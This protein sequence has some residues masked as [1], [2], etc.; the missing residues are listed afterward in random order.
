MTDRP[1]RDFDDLLLDSAGA[2]RAVPVGPADGSTAEST[3]HGTAA[4]TAESAPTAHVRES[5]PD[6]PRGSWFDD[7]HDHLVATTGR[8]RLWELGLPILV[9]VVAAVLR[10]WNL[11]HPRSLVFDETF[12]VKDAWTL[13]N[14]GFEGAWPENPDPGFATGAVDVFTGAPSFVVHPPLGKWIIGLGMGLLGADDSVGWRLATAIVGILAVALVIVIGKLLFRSTFLASLAGLLLAIDGHAIVMSRVS[15]LDGILMFVALCGVAA[16]LLDRRW[17]EE[18]MAVKV[19]A[20]DLPS[21]GPVLWWRPWLLTA[22]LIFGLAAGVKWTGIYFLA[23]Y[24]VYAV[25]VD[26]LLRR[27]A[28][29]PFWVSGA[30]LKQGPVTFLLVV[31]I[32]LIAYLGTWLGW[33]RTSGGWARQWATEAP[34]NAWSGALAWVP[35]WAQSLWHY[36]VQMYDYSINLRATHPYEANPLTWLLMLRPT[37]MYFV[38]QATGVDGCAAVRCDEA[39]TSVA[40]PLIWYAGVL[41]LVYLLYRLA[42]YREWRAGFVLMGIVAGYLPW[43]LYLDRTVFQFYCVVFEPYMMLALALTAGVVI[44]KRG[45]ERGRRTRGIVIVLIFVVLAAALTAYFYPLWTG[46]QTSFSFWQAHMWLPS[47]V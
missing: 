11:G 16:I 15:L 25:V 17:A 20:G 1:Q 18:R 10:L 39:I 7:V 32:A 21:W 47:W 4:S 38:D 35:D 3:A 28:G 31:P 36:H 30:I 29:V 12:Y 8:R 5:A 40:N 37:S 23:A 19:A 14:L 6:L 45:D 13:W 46:Q 33:L 24:G 27:R 42:R 44:G 26:A 41:A 9:V 2:S 34:G 43:M 22:G